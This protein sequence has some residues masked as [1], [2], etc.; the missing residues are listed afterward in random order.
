SATGTDSSS[1]VAVLLFKS[2]VVG[3]GVTVT[4]LRSGPP[5]SS[6]TVSV[7][8]QVTVA[9]TGRPTVVSLIVPVQLDAVPAV[10]TARYPAP[11]P[12]CERRRQA[13]ARIPDPRRH[14][15]YRPLR[16][17]RAA[18]RPHPSAGHAVRRPLRSGPHRHPGRPP[19][20]LPRAPRRGQLGPAA[21]GE[22]PRQSGRAAGAGRDPGARAKYRRRDYRPL[23]SA[24]A[25]LPGPVDRLHLGP[26]VDPVR[27]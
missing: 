21:Q 5:K 12:H 1:S 6:G 2:T 14:R 3:P 11:A 18:G 7:S 24:R 19:R 20:R 8:L 10:P 25:R 27:G 23:R 17:R 16:P 9:P 4:V 22:L 13:H 15:R 26:G